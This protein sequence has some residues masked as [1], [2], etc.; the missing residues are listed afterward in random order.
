VG[1]EIKR[2]FRDQTWAVHVTCD[3]QERALRVARAVPDVA[4]RLGRRVRRASGAQPKM[5]R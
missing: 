5:P 2:C 3:L 4:R 1:G